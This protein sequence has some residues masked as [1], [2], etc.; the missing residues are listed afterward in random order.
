[1]GPQK[2]KTKR[3]PLAVAL[4]RAIRAYRDKLEINQDELA[5][6][7]NVHRAY[8]SSIEQGAVNITVRKLKQ[9]SGGLNAK[10]SDLLVSIGL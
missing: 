10:P 3:D 9:V 7:S 2:R 1:M 8:M 5:H 4:G 6:R